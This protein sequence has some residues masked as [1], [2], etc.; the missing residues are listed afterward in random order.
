MPADETESPGLEARFA[1]LAGD[2]QRAAADLCNGTLPDLAGVAREA[3]AL[4]AAFRA[5]AACL[6]IE[7][8]SLPE[9]RR[10]QVLG[11]RAEAA[12]ATLGRLEHRDGIDSPQLAAVRKRRDELCRRLAAAAPLDAADTEPL[13]ALAELLERAAA[14]TD[15]EAAELAET[16]ARGLG[17]AVA[18]AALRG[19]LRLAAP[20][21]EAR[22]AVATPPAVAADPVPPS[23]AREAANGEAP[24]DDSL[25]REASTR[26][27][28]DREG[29][30]LESP[31]PGPPIG[32][33]GT[34]DVPSQ[35]SQIGRA[36]IQEPPHPVMPDEGASPAESRPQ[37]PGALDAS[38]GAS[39]AGVA[40]ASPRDGAPPPRFASPPDFG[41]ATDLVDRQHVEPASDPAP[42]PHLA[43]A[44]DVAPAPHFAVASDVV[45]APHLAP[46]SDLA[47]TPDLA[48]AP[49]VAPAPDLALASGVGRPP[50][51]G[52]GTPE[53]PAGRAATPATVAAPTPSTPPARSPH[54]ERLR[55][56][57]WGLLRADRCGLAYQVARV[58]EAPPVPVAVVKAAA[59]GLEVVGP[60]GALAAVLRET[61][62]AIAL[63][64]RGAPGEHDTFGV[65]EGDANRAPVSRDRVHDLLLA[66]AALRPSLL[67]WRTGAPA[68]LRSVALPGA[69]RRLADVVLRAGEQLN[70]CVPSRVTGVAAARE[71]EARR[72]ALAEETRAFRARASA[73]AMRLAHT[74]DMWR[75]L[76]SPGGVVHRLFPADA[77]EMADLPRL[78]AA[79]DALD[80]EEAID[81]A[82][83]SVRIVHQRP[84]VGLARAWMAED[85]REAISLAEQWIALFDV[86]PS[87]GERVEQCLGDAHRGLEMLLPEAIAEL[88]ALA[89]GADA[90][91]A[92]GRVLRG[93]LEGLPRLLAP[94]GPLAGGAGWAEEPSP[95]DLL[96]AD[97]LLGDVA[98]TDAL[99]PEGTAEEIRTALVAMLDGQVDWAAAYR[100]HVARG[101]TLAA[102]R[103]LRRMERVAPGEADAL[104]ETTRLELTERRADVQRSL[105]QTRSAV[106]QAATHGWL[107]EDERADMD[108]RV[109]ALALAGDGPGRGSQAR[110]EVAAI[111]EALAARRIEETAIRR[112]RLERSR[113]PE[114]VRAHVNARLAHG[115]LLAA[116]EDVARA[117]AGATLDD[118][119]EPGDVF[120]EFFPGRVGALERAVGADLLRPPTSP[121]GPPDAPREASEAGRPRG[122]EMMAS[123]YE[124]KLRRELDAGHVRVILHALG[125][126]PVRAEP[127]GHASLDVVGEPIRDRRRV[128][129]DAFGSYANGRYRILGLWQ[130]PSEEDLLARLGETATQPAT[131]ALFFGR[132]GVERRRELARIARARRRTFV[133]IDEI[134]LA[135]LATTRGP[136][137]SI[138]FRLALPF[139]HYE[140]YD[141]TP[142][143]VS[144]EMFFG[145]ER[146]AVLIAQGSGPCFVH[147][148]PQSGK[149]ALLRHVERARHAPLAGSIVRWID[150]KA[151]RIGA[152]DT[153]ED[154]WP[155]LARELVDAGI[156]ARRLPLIRAGRV[157]ESVKL[158]LDGSLS[159]RFHVLLDGADLF[160]AQD[161]LE[162]FRVTLAL[163]DLIEE[164]EGRFKV[165]FA[166]GVGVFRASR[167]ARHPLAAFG[168]SI[169]LGPLCEGADV[170]AAHAL[171]EEPLGV[172]G[173]RFRSPGSPARVLAHA[174]HDPALVQRFGGLLLRHLSAEAGPPYWIAPD[175]VEAVAT[176]AEWREAVRQRLV[177]VLALDARYEVIAGALGLAVLERRIGLD[178]GAPVDWFRAQAG[179]WWPDGRPAIQDGELETLLEE[180]SGLGIL[181]ARARGQF[182]FR[183]P[184]IILAIGSAHD[185]EAALRRR[186]ESAGPS[187]L[188][189]S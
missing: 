143:L 174:G 3:L 60:G 21:A 91:V 68:A 123:F 69:L 153:A 13:V 32:E 5:E 24:R 170:R 186:R 164:T 39:G 189:A 64:E 66:A 129:L 167:L 41:A 121:F 27:A 26:D 114:P 166:G 19:A 104:R 2:L 4:D 118:L 131:I 105:E 127:S 7:T 75:A 176:S 162:Q 130:W 98:L 119:T 53:A 110:A 101:D 135:F 155:R 184:R 178:A 15:E 156:L 56:E 74:R 94:A 30:I 77:F 63:A 78:H 134:A 82:D 40:A 177:S 161:A 84:L 173:Y 80:V 16:T 52:P 42:A 25:I 112:T 8:A 49:P 57:F 95:Q 10:A 140:P 132:L 89:A 175:H 17:A 133:V 106:E 33:S 154:L 149:T 29:P 182:A 62:A 125:F 70:S 34:R 148:A 165:V 92:A 126:P 137:L 172:L 99:E 122:G 55:R 147:G 45:P 96:G 54:D 151:E 128:P 20:P 67:A 71:W 115:D 9:V 117:E 160:L 100:R 1:A 188:V 37:A 65:T 179:R 185:V 58:L 158:W 35:E 36:A 187:A 152:A 116:D 93:A 113:L 109:V 139:A 163:R 46:A 81:A 6:G 144:E 50:T 79:L 157:T 14:L 44:S 83:R 159:R 107:R 28:A 168:P 61:F 88:D 150:L 108:A 103:I 169:A 38:I 181:R 138:L 51:D 145:R 23:P 12:L 141:T 22:S 18:V 111:Q 43:V 90:T 124:L 73:R 87:L 86:R 97:L 48:P 142:G 11:R 59:L 180:M 85:V 72:E 146:E 136:R 76:T 31:A 120:A 47:A 171:V 183:D 102:G